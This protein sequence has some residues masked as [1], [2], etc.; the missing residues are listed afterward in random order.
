MMASIVKIRSRKFD[1][2]CAKHKRYSPA[3]DGRGGVP[4]GCP[5]CNLLCDIWESSLKLN[6]LIRRFD[7]NHDDLER[8]REPKPPAGDPRQ[9]SLI[10]D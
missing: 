2:R 1:G 7:P 5:R 9:M 8:P 10:T 4:G 3:V 6:Q